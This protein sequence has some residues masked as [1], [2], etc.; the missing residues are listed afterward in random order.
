LPRRS[1]HDGGS[2]GLGAGARGLHASLLAASLLL[3]APALRAS[4]EFAGVIDASSR[5]LV[6]LDDPAT[7]ASSGW[8]GLGGQFEDCVVKSYD[9]A[10]GTLTVLRGGVTVTLTLRGAHVRPEVPGSKGTLTLGS[11]ADAVTSEVEISSPGT[12]LVPLGDGFSIEITLREGAQGGSFNMSSVAS[13]PPPSDGRNHVR[14]VGS[15]GSNATASLQLAGS[16]VSGGGVGQG[17]TITL[18]GSVA[19]KAFRF[20]FRQPTAPEAPRPIQA[21]AGG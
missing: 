13:G 21:Q 5:V 18:T 16:T 7:K 4:L 10:K 2:P 19:G 14:I 3:A 17:P 6:L 20:S 9:P 15:G 1:S 11:G 12:T 8:I